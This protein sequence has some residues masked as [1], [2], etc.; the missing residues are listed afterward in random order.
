MTSRQSIA[1]RCPSCGNTT[2]FLTESGDLC[3]SWIPCRQPGLGTWIDQTKQALL[4]LTAAHQTTTDA[5][6]QARTE[7]AAYAQAAMQLLQAEADRDHWKRHAGRMADAARIGERFYLAERHDLLQALLTI[8]QA[9]LQGDSDEGAW[10][11]DTAR[12]ALRAAGQ[13]PPATT[14]PD[15]VRAALQ[16]ICDALEARWDAGERRAIQD[17]YELLRLMDIGRAALA[18]PAQTPADAITMDSVTAY[19]EPV[20]T[21]TAGPPAPHPDSHDGLRLQ[22]TTL[23]SSL[24]AARAELQ[25]ERERW[26]RAAA[27]PG[28]Q[29]IGLGT[30]LRRTYECWVHGHQVYWNAISDR[31]ILPGQPYMGLPHCDRCGKRLAEQMRICVDGAPTTD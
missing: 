11:R 19:R 5:L 22:I 8:A 27:D 1:T 17:P 9:N 10:L 28:A 20:S 15:P 3:C 6:A 23:Q 30:W 26:T 18:T 7:R 24:R 21:A 29:S 31:T 13:R 12:V 14:T 4:E 16:Q 2:L 25:D